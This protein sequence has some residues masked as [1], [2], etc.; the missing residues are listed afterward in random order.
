MNKYGLTFNHLGLAVSNQ[1]K[2]LNFLK[3]LGYHIG[4]EVFDP[5]Q[6]VNLV[7]C[8]SQTMPDVEV[9]SQSKQ[10]SPLDNIL[11][12]NRDL[13]Y[14]ACYTTDNLKDTLSSVEQ[15]QNKF[16]CIL[17]PKPAILFSGKLVSFYLV[18]G[19]GIIEIME[20]FIP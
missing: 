3:G 10:P 7:L 12:K 14:H 6:N 9:V 18:N 8:R 4:D 20:N 13:I 19:F 11:K 15:D 16:I 5:E 17:P 1:A 2:A